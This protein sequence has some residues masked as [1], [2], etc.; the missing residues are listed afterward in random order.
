MK[1]VKKKVTVHLFGKVD[2]KIFGKFFV[3]L[4]GWRLIG[5]WGDGRPTTCKREIER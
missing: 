5:E 4:S 3:F 2:R 1:K